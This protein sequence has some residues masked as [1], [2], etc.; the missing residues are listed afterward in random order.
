MGG[1]I[2][3]ARNGKFNFRVAVIRSLF[4][5]ARRAAPSS[6]VTCVRRTPRGGVHCDV[7]LRFGVT[8]STI[9]GL[10]GTSVLLVPNRVVLFAA[11]ITPELLYG[12]S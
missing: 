12:G 1:L 7:I 8:M 9:R 6:R 4:C 3:N 11:Q 10:V 2:Y 5:L